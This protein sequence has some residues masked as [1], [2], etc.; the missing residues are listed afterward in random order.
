MR[1]IKALLAAGSLIL[2]V[3][4]ASANTNGQQSLPNAGN[5]TTFTAAV[6]E[7]ATITIPA[8]FSLPIPDVTQASTAAATN[9]GAFSVTNMVTNWG[10]AVELQ[11]TNPAAFTVP[12]GSTASAPSAADLTVHGVGWSATGNNASATVSAAAALSATGATTTIVTS[13][14]NPEGGG[15][16]GDVNF[17][18]ANTST[19]F[20]VGGNYTLVLTWHVISTN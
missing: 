12:A 7:Q 14:T 13:A 4:A 6:A 18:L 19:D 17:S 5:A 20:L 15:M 8:A 10:G 1:T 11:L 2:A 16:S 3:G 9:G